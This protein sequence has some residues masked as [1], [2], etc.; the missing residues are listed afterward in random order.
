[1]FGMAAPIGPGETWK[2]VVKG[3]PVAQGRMSAI[4]VTRREGDRRVPVLG[5]GGLPIVNQTYTNESKLK[6]WRNEVAQMA[7]YGGWRA[8]GM[9]AL[10]EACELRCTFVFKRPDS[11]FGTGRNAGV[12]KDSAPLY[13]ELTGADLDKLERAIMDALT[14]IVWKDDRRVVTGHHRRRYGDVEQVEIEVRR[15]RVRTVGELRELRGS[16]P[17]LADDLADQLR[18]ELAV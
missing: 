7:V 16:A 13:P 2:L 12:L 18:I 8:L 6:P 3:T 4:P 17:D 15:P 9:D 10:D 1:M 11:H 5:K 14:G